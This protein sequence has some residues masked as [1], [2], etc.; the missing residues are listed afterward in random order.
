MVICMYDNIYNM[1]LKQ[2]RNEI[3]L[4]RDELAIFKRKYEDIIYN[5]DDENFSS[6]FVKE[7][8]DMKAAIE[9]TAEGIK[10]KVSNEELAKYTTLEQTANAITSHAFASADLSSAEEISDI[11]DAIDKTK[12]YYIKD[13]NGNKTYYYY[14]EISKDWEEIIGGGIE[15]VFEQTETGFKLKGNVLIDGDT[16]VTEN[17]RLSGIVTWDMDNSPVK[18]QYSSDKTNWHDSF[19]NGDEYMRMTFNGK[20]YGEA[21]KIVGTDGSDGVVNY[22]R[23]NTILENSYGIEST[24]LGSASISS[25]TIYSAEIYSPNIYGQLLTLVAQNSIN[26]N[27]YNTMYLTPT[28]MSLGNA[29]NSNEKEKFAIDLANDVDNSYVLMRLGAGVNDDNMNSLIIE[30]YIDYIK[31]GSNTQNH[32]FVGLTI[33]PTTGELCFYG[34]SFG[35]DLDVSGGDGYAKFG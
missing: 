16:V 3:Q 29:Y 23:V 35:G 4:L 6:R 22:S 9:V 33:T 19:S 28:G 8:G 18:A 26:T 1:D 17:L 5:L 21:V 12:T 24:T 25:P 31:I 2:L 34:D 15:S 20:D 13:E 27:V 32:G 10:T 14:N 11:K 30:K 7:K